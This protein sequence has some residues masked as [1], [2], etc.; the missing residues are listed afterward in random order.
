MAAFL[1]ARRTMSFTFYVHLV[2]AQFPVE[3]IL[4]DKH[5]RISAGLVS[6]QVE[7]GLLRLDL[8]WSRG[9]GRVILGLLFGLLLQIHRLHTRAAILFHHQL[10]FELVIGGLEGSVVLLE[11]LK[12][13]LCLSLQQKHRK[14]KPRV[15]QMYRATSHW[16]LDHT[17]PDTKALTQR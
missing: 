6:I 15:N 8:S 14:D 12:D 5:A 7:V 1:A 16:G 17:G 3:F 10:L 9:R 4:T 2:F 11:G 13:G